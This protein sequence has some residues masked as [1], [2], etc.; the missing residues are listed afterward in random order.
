MTIDNLENDQIILATGGYDHTIKLWQTHT[1]ICNRTMQHAES[2]VNALEIT[3]D[4][5]LLAA[6]SYQHIYMYD[7]TS[8]NS[9]AVVNYEGT[10]KNVTS[11]GFQEDG[12]WMYSGGEDCRARIWDLRSRNNQC[13][14]IFEVQAPINCVCLHPNQAELFVGDQNGIIYRWDL[15]TDNNEQLIPE[16]DAMILD[17]AISPDSQ[18]M[19]SVNNKGRCYIWS[20]ISGN[21]DIPTKLKPKHKFDAHKRYALKCK[22]SPDSDLLITTSADQTAKIW[23]TIDFSLLQE[24]KQES[25]RWVWDAAF[26]ADGQYVFTAS[27]DLCAKLW[28]VK[29]GVMEREYSG[30]QKAV[31]A[32]AFRD[33]P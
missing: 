2:Q 9:S 24:L 29:T 17:I 5:Q 23:S 31:T 4:K 26:S 6:A 27:S 30:H 18:L 10:S 19:A 15:R 32:L 20:L 25:Q 1:G 8:N 3:P 12:K 13:P 21:I 16:N 11:V 28:N 22:F 33:A 14:K 7:L